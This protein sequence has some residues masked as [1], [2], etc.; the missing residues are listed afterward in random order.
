MCG[1][2]PVVRASRNRSFTRNEAARQ[3]ARALRRLN[4]TAMTDSYVSCIM[5]NRMTGMDRNICCI[6]MCVVGHVL[7]APIIST[8][9]HAAQMCSYQ[10]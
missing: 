8:L 10:Y 1:G 4:A 2:D 5:T 7:Y 3:G 6:Y 9:S